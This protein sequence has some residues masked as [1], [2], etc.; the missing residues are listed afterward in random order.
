VIWN[1]LLPLYSIL[2]FL[3]IRATLSPP[4]L[5]RCDLLYL[6]PLSWDT[7]VSAS[8]CRVWEKW[9]VCHKM[10]CNFH[11][12]LEMC[13]VST[14]AWTSYC[15]IGQSTWRCWLIVIVVLRYYQLCE[16]VL[17]SSQELALLSTEFHARY[18]HPR[19][20]KAEPAVSS[21][22]PESPERTGVWTHWCK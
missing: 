1:S 7:L 14:T 22:I 18:Q 20:A 4:T 6:M 16:W 10:S 8:T 3:K 15:P 12:V 2:Y 19:G 21:E 11:L 17:F 9:P 5:L 13:T